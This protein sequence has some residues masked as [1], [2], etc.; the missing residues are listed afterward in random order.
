MCDRDGANALQ[1]TRFGGATGCPR[2]S[3]DSRKIVLEASDGIYVVDVAGGLPRRL[4]HDD[5]SHLM[6]SWSGDGRWIYF[7]HIVQSASRDPSFK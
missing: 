5:W 7:V 2:W 3:P 1:L 6:P 4:T